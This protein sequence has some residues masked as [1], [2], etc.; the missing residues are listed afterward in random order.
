MEKF[1]RSVS[2]FYRL[3]RVSQLNLRFGP[4]AS[5]N[6]SYALDSRQAHSKPINVWNQ[7]YVRQY[8]SN[9]RPPSGLSGSKF[10]PGQQNM[11]QEEESEMPQLSMAEIL[12]RE[13]QDETAELSQHLST[14]QF[15]GFSV[16]ANDADVKLTKQVGNA[17]VTVRFTVSSSLTEWAPAQQAEI[18]EQTEEENINSKLVSMPEFQ[19]QITKNNHTL[20]VSCYFEEMDVDEESGQPQPSE[21]YFNIDELV[22]YSGE[23]KEAEYAVSAEY[24][25]EDLQQSLLDYLADHGVDEAFAKNLVDF[26]TSYEKKQYIGLMKRLKTFVSRP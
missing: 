6:I 14:D 15:P 26:S 5:T 2:L 20:E 19:V 24:F 11:N 12:D 22:L 13:I 17:T 9:Q 21:P 1:C 4:N 23:P 16:E 18:T 10:N 3:P 7:S 25:Q 8:S